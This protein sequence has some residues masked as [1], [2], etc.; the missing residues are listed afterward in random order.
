VLELVYRN[1]QWTGVCNGQDEHSFPD[2]RREVVSWTDRLDGVAPPFQ[3]A[4]TV[5]AQLQQ[6]DF[7]THYGARTCDHV[8]G[9]TLTV[10][11]QEFYQTGLKDASGNYR[12]DQVWLALRDV[13]PENRYHVYYDTDLGMVYESADSPRMS[14][15]GSNW[16]ILTDTNAPLTTSSVVA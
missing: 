13:E 4:K 5:G 16:M 11:R 12:S 14:S 3:T 6:K 8:V 9:P 1:N 2:G 10:D 7:E 15:Q